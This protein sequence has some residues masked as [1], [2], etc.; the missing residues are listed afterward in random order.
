MCYTFTHK[1]HRLH[2]H[3]LTHLLPSHINMASA[4]PSDPT[5]PTGKLCTWINTIRLDSIPSPVLERAKFLILDGLACAL[6][7]AH[8]PWSEIATKTVMEMEGTGHC[9]VIGWDKKLH[10]LSAALLNSTFLQGFELDDYH[11]D[12]PL[13]SNSIILPALLAV[14][15]QT[16]SQNK[17]KTKE[18][19]FTGAEFVLATIV[20]Y[21]VGPRVGMALYGLDMLTRGWHS[22][23]VFGPSASAAAVSKLLHLPSNEIEDALGMACTQAGGLMSAQFE[24]MVKRMQHGFAARNGLFAALLAKGGYKGIKR[25]YER[26][27]GGFLSCFGQGSGK[28]PEYV[29]DEVAK[30]L[31]SFW[32]CERIV[33]KPYSSL[34]FTHAT[35]DCVRG[36]QEKFPEHFKDRGNLRKIRKITVEQAGPTFKHGGWKAER[37]L[38]VIGAQ[39]NCAYVAATQFVDG[40]VL[41]A[42]FATNKLDRNE[43]WELVGK[44]GC[45]ENPAFNEE[46]KSYRQRMIVEFLD[47]RERVEMTVNAPRGVDPALTNEEVL[48]KWRGLTA[49]CIEMK[50]RDKIERMVM[51]IEGLEDIGLLANLLLGETKS[52]IE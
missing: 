16:R 4:H 44:I 43:I 15:E 8:L 31:G 20:G 17:D 22:G 26:E 45:V 13:H 14:A 50:R 1:Q 34:A 32:Q 35:V 30:G 5:G 18:A 10:P 9:T 46:G 51:G 21:E 28:E 52:P 7:G 6:V 42:Q 11:Q 36:L 23:A 25:V 38:E 33:V 27:Y 39:M 12:A 49:D 41:P 29:V 40:Q 24:S 48:E 2:A 19:A 47:A 3:T 37:P